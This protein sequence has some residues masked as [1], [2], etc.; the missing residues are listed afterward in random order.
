MAEKSQHE[1]HEAPFVDAPLP[2]TAIE[3]TRLV[4][5]N[6]DVRD[7]GRID[8][9]LD[10][11]LGR[12]L[13]K[14]VRDRDSI[15]SEPPPPYSETEPA[16]REW[17]IKL[18]IVIQ[19]VGSRGDVQPFIALGNALQKYGHRVRIGTHN[20]FED[21]V[22]GSGLEFYPIGGDPADLMA[23]MVKNPGLIPSMKAL[24][25]GDIGRKRAMVAEMLDGCWKSCIEPDQRTN[26]P[27]TADAIIGN[28]PA[29]A[30]IHCA[31]ALGI[32]VHLMFTMPWTSTRAFPHPLANIKSKDT[33]R[34][35]ANYISYGIV[36]FLTWQGLGDVI[37]KWRVGIDL[38]PVPITEGP[39]LAKTLQVPFTYCWS[40][41]LVP[42]P[43]DWQPHIDVCGFFFRDPPSYTP[44]S[45]LEDFL[46]AG[47]PP[48]YIGFG[49]IVI[50][51]PAR[52]TALLLEA[53][54]MAGVRAIISRGWS[55]L[56]GA[57]KP[58][59]FWLGDCPHEWLFQHVS[60]VVH[61]GGAGTTACGLLNGKPTT[62]VPFFG[63]QPFW[64]DMVAAAGA[65]PSPIPHRQ[66]DSR[67]LAEA[68]TY[69]LTP[70]ASD[71]AQGIAAKMRAE[72]GVENAVHSFHAHLPLERIPCDLIP[73]RPAFWLYKKGKTRMKLSKLAAGL[74]ATRLDLNR[75]HFQTYA[76]HQI[77]IENRRW[78]PVTGTHSAGIGIMKDLVE[79]TAGIFLN[80]VQEYRRIQRTS[81]DDSDTRSQKKAES[82]AARSTRPPSPASSLS[83]FDVKQIKDIERFERP[84]LERAH[85]S[86]SRLSQR[87]KPPQY[88]A[89]MARKELPRDS[90][91]RMSHAS[92]FSQYTSVS[93]MRRSIDTSHSEITLQS[94]D[95]PQ[96]SHTARP[97]P[98]PSR[99]DSA[100]GASIYSTATAK[101]KR[102]NKSLAMAKAS[103]K[104]FGKFHGHFFKGT[105]VDLPYATAEGLLALPGYV[106][107][108]PSS[109]SR[110]L[111]A[112]PSSDAASTT[113]KAPSAFA[114]FIDGPATHAP[115]TD[116]RSGAVAGAKTFA[117]GMTSGLADFVVQPYRGAKAEGG[118]GAVKGAGRGVVSGLSKTSAGVLGLVAF[119]GHG[120]T[121]SLRAGVYCQR[122][123]AVVARRWEESEWLVGDVWGMEG[124]DV[125]VGRVIRAFETARRGGEWSQYDE[126]N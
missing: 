108:T 29:F 5:E 42:K 16:R 18:N 7:D 59:V 90:P 75:K 73:N 40:P 89:A 102:E 32:P 91:S 9:D 33:D 56:G 116:W 45:D 110:S 60:A 111:A 47:P 4:D 103:L 10:S 11:A 97:T 48:V 30:P 64:G 105:L 81:Y 38:E 17:H 50:D 49:S 78:D 28:P 63:D 31:E 101:P 43:A 112:G 104:S 67:I 21:F 14:L 80:P 121:K 36:E 53:V 66:L 96:T 115:I 34:R 54:H 118:W 68:I 100:S 94:P 122:A 35:L 86:S 114:A 87:S 70:E 8:V 95:R 57:N 51:E 88:E 107:S 77:V 52:M 19:V 46:R 23:Y 126:L 83:S 120:L 109:S 22:R 117:Y 20:V 79:D 26:M 71:A 6:T 124:V 119:P 106:G 13:S 2:Y 1:Y 65:G 82:V 98:P 84:D 72:N 99:P 92:Q 12:R 85:T 61:H 44:P 62:I 15:F 39:N 93:S 3:T 74:V 69:C 55:K 24:R 76:P 58:N 25:A 37:N 125:D 41:A 123:K 113:S 27:F